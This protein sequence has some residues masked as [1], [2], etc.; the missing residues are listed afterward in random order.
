VDG[1]QRLNLVCPE[2]NLSNIDVAIRHLKEN[3]EKYI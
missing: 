1:A 3:K 2:G